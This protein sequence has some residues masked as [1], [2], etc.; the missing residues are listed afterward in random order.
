M[1][2]WD[3]YDHWAHGRIETAIIPNAQLDVFPSGDMWKWELSVCGYGGDG[4]MGVMAAGSSDTEGQAK[5]DAI[6]AA[7]KHF[8]RDLDATQRILDTLKS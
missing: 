8:Q 5:A 3:E 4:D 7:I 1:V 2:F 6:Q